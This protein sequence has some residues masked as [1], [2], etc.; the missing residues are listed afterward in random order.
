MLDGAGICSTVVCPY[1]RW[2]YRLDGSL[3]NAPQQATQLPDLV[4]SEWGLLPVALAEW[5]GLLF[6]NPDATAPAFEDWIAPLEAHIGAYHPEA[7]VDLV[8]GV[9]P[10]AD[11]LGQLVARGVVVRAYVAE[12]HA[13]R[14]R[15][16]RSPT[17]GRDEGL[18]RD[19]PGIRPQSCRANS[20][21]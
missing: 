9:G 19:A 5:R 11:G 4:A 10:A 15:V 17:I 14:R 7:L 3:K 20:A 12:P 16:V 1:H 8:A 13:R 6:V 18:L 2:Q 21:R